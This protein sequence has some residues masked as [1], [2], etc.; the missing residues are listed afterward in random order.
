M[1]FNGKWED[2]LDKLCKNL[3]KK[4]TNSTFQKVRCYECYGGMFIILIF[5]G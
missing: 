4:W 1:G 3:R 2:L 5:L